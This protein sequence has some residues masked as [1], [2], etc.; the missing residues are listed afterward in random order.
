MHI[1]FTVFMDFLVV[2]AST[3]LTG[4]ATL[5]YATIFLEVGT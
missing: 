1:F 4:Q 5:I 2:F 3:L